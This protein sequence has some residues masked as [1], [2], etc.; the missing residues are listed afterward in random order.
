HK[1]CA[2][3]VGQGH[4]RSAATTDAGARSGV[5]TGA[6]A[7]CNAAPSA[8]PARSA[9]DNR[10]SSRPATCRG[11]PFAGEPRATRSR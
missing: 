1:G 10:T 9:A 11:E 5:A 2:R 6:R 7:G 8:C 3:R 4:D